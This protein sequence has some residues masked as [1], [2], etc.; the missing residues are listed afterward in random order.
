MML[1]LTLRGTPTLYNGDE[2][3]LENVPIPPERVR[4]PFGIRQPGTDQGRDPVRTPMPW[5]RTTHCGFT[6]GEPW[7]PLGED[8]AGH[9]VEA[10]EGDPDSVLTLTRALLDLRRRE[11]ALSL[12][13]WA[14]S[15]VEG[16]VLAYARTWGERRVVVVLN[17]EPMPKT[18]RFNAPLAGRIELSTHPASA[19]RPVDDRLELAGDEGVIIATE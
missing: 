6:T 14:P 13:D 16:D 15:T 8:R 5:D 1:L 9:S 3:G 2:L 19:H 12:G 17:L 10:Q 4:D 18:V 7:L 11:P